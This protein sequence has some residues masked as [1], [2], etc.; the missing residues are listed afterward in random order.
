MN[1]LWTHVTSWSEFEN[2]KLLL[3]INSI[4]GCGLLAIMTALAQVYEIW[5][6]IISGGMEH[7]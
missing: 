6:M 1:I 7:K 4:S 2:A 5:L 3:E